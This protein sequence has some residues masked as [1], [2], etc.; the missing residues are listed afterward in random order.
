MSA[1]ADAP[2]AGS[3]EA[4]F[5]TYRQVSAQRDAPRAGSAEAKFANLWE[6][7]SKAG[8]TPCR[9][10]RGKGRCGLPHTIRRAMHPVQAAPRQR[11]T[12]VLPLWNLMM[13]PV[14]AAPRQSP[15]G[16]FPGRIPGVMHP[17]QA[18]PRQSPW[19]GL[20]GR[21]PGMHPLQ[22]A[23]RQRR[24][25][26]ALTVWAAGCTPCSQRR[27]KGIPHGRRAAA[28]GMHPV[29]AAHSE[30]TTCRPMVL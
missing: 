25:M 23:P 2:R 17:V 9:Q 16:G 8:C 4:K 5:L 26:M 28:T 10:R 19:G 27:G 22:A 18:A 14:Q 30:I 21:I 13:H 15:R 12:N 24:S 7:I 20:P 3:A 6:G 11:N 29:Q 1:F